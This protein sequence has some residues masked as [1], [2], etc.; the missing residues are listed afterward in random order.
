M[1]RARSISIPWP[2]R[3]PLYA[4]RGKGSELSGRCFSSSSLKILEFFA[5]G[6]QALQPIAGALRACSRRGKAVFARDAVLR[7]RFR[8]ARA[9]QS[10]SAS[11]F[12]ETPHA[13]L[14]AH[15]K[16]AP[17]SAQRNRRPSRS[18][19]QSQ[20]KYRRQRSPSGPQSPP[21]KICMAPSRDCRRLRGAMTFARSTLTLCALR[22]RRIE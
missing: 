9:A 5:E 15:R 14:A 22:A 19:C 7:R 1:L 16:A 11:A 2:A 10:F 17:Q 13:V 4:T 18:Q 21:M 20:P 8:A 12:S 3:S 6:T